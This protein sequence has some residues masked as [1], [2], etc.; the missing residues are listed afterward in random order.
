MTNRFN[1]IIRYAKIYKTQLVVTFAGFVV[2]LLAFVGMEYGWLLGQF[3]QPILDYLVSLRQESITFFMQT[4]SYITEPKLF[5]ILIFVAILVWYMYAKDSL[6]PLSFAIAISASTIISFFAKLLFANSRPPIESMIV[7]I[8][9]DYSF[10][11]GHT[12][13][14]FVTATMV[15]YIFLLGIK[16]DVY[17]RIAITAAA[18]AATL[19]ALSRLYLGYHWMTDVIASIGLGLVIVSFVIIGDKYVRSKSLK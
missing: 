16:N 3:N 13:I 7:P 4:V 5:A 17:R 11:S 2:F 19:V 8:E 12:I 14:A 6:K 9:V 10:P 1:Q 15:I 18:L